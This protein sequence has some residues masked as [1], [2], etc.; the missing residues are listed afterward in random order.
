MDCPVCLDTLSQSKMVRV[1][2]C[3]HYLC[4]PCAITCLATGGM[5]CPLCRQPSSGISDSTLKP[6]PSRKVLKLSRD[7][8][9]HAGITLKNQGHWV[10]VKSL[11][12][13]D[14]AWQAG[15][16]PGDRIASLNGVPA[17]HHKDAV[18]LIQR[19]TDIGEDVEVVLYPRSFKLGT[20]KTP[21]WLSCCRNAVYVVDGTVRQRSQHK[22]RHRLKA[23]AVQVNRHR[24]D[25]DSSHS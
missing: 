13:K 10:T 18:R 21:S 23:L 17:V 19:A 9:R 6:G 8:P 22:E 3:Q 25:W 20:L 2:P 1:K 24:E 12:E 5:L 11:V 7:C 4:R 15:L 14:E 16:L